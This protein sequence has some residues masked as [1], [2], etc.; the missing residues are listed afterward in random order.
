MHSVRRAVRRKTVRHVIFRDV[1]DGIVGRIR[2]IGGGADTPRPTP[3]RIWS[4][5][6]RS[7]SDVR[8]I[9]LGKKL[10]LLVLVLL[11]WEESL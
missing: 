6:N 3:S 1:L 9:I 2:A 7:C 8:F 11:L 4:R 5:L 10:P